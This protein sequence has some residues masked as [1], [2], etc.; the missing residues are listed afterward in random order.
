[1]GAPQKREKKYRKMGISL[2]SEVSQKLETYANK[3]FKGNSARKDC[4]KD[5]S[6]NPNNSN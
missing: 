5:L 4:T 2:E 6:P 1:L 3:K